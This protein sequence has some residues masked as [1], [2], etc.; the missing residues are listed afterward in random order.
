VAGDSKGRLNSAREGWEGAVHGEV[1]EFRGGDHCRWAL[2]GG[3]GWE[4]VL[5]V[6]SLVR[7]LLGSLNFSLDQRRGRGR[8]GKGLTGE[9]VDDGA[10]RIVLREGAERD[11]R[12]SCDE[13]GARGEPFIGARGKG[14]RWSFL[15]PASY[16]VPPIN[17][18]QRCRGDTTAGRYRRGR[19]SRGGEDG[20][21]P[22]FPVRQEDGG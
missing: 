17:A 9:V 21:V 18:A 6:R 8:R 19:W 3:W 12:G 20:A 13:E 15:A 10:S 16:T 2:G 1:A 14:G 4:V 11:G 5:R 22:N 7:E